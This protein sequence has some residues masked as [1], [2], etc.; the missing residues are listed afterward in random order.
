MGNTAPRLSTVSRSGPDP[1]VS[2]GSAEYDRLEKVLGDGISSSA[3]DGLEAIC[4]NYL[5]WRRT[6]LLAEKVS[7]V[8]A[9]FTRVEGAVGEF[10]KLSSGTLIPLTDSGYALERVWRHHLSRPLVQ[11]WRRDVIELTEATTENDFDEEATGRFLLRLTPDAIMQLRISLGVAVNWTKK[12]LTEWPPARP[13]RASFQALRSRPFLL[14]C[15]TG[16][17]ATICRTAFQ[18]PST[19]IRPSARSSAR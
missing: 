12:R 11:L 17:P 1:H 19:E 16:P 2:L 5:M 15:R 7:D 8:A 13:G 6:E 9:L 4:N 10:Q 18:G 3:R 14:S